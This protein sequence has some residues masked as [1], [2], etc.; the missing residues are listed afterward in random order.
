MNQADFTFHTHPPVVAELID[1]G[2]QCAAALR[3]QAEVAIV[4]PSQFRRAAIHS[5][6]LAAQL[7]VIPYRLIDLD[8]ASQLRQL[9]LP[10]FLTVFGRYLK[11]LN[12]ACILQSIGKPLNDVLSQT[13]PTAPEE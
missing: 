5:E 10:D 2:L 6:L 8:Q 13:I 12:E 4:P 1:Y 3:F 11:A 9:E 7:A